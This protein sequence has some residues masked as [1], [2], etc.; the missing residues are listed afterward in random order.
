[1]NKDAPTSGE[2]FSRPTSIA[3]DDTSGV[4]GPCSLIGLTKGV[5]ANASG[6]G[7]E[8]FTTSISAMAGT[9]SELSA[10]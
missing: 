5:R 3:R 7:E 4:G 8:I 2:G 9:S 1:M 10:L 6:D